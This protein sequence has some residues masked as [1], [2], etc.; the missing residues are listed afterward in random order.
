MKLS[1]LEIKQQTFAKSMRGFDVAEVQSFLNVVSNEWEHLSNKCRDQEQE[2]RRLTDKL[3][4]YQK[5]EEALHE[6]LQTA[7]ESAQ[8]RI[9][10]S[11]Q[12]AQNR[13]SQ[14]DLE[15]EKIVRDAHQ[16][17]QAIRQSIQRL[18]ERRHEIIR[19]ME[20]YLELATESLDT[21]RRDDSS[22][23]SLPKEESDTSPPLRQKSADS[24]ST[25]ASPAAGTDD[26]DHLL[27]DIDE[28]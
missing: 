26:L 16:E 20:S 23:Y 7:K 5:V 27:D 3:E 14:A 15:A 24:A 9:S 12:E 2:I 11:K 28:D 1:A 18:L 6:T 21:F 13:I 22:T 19:G 8:Q 4:H 10:S 17:R 25:A